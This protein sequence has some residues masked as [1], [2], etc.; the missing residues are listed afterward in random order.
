MFRT[1]RFFVW[2]SGATPTA[3][4]MLTMLSGLHR[5]N[6]WIDGLAGSG[7]NEIC[8]LLSLVVCAGYMR[9]KRTYRWFR[10]TSKKP[11]AEMQVVSRV[12][13]EHPGRDHRRSFRQFRAETARLSSRS[14]DFRSIRRRCRLCRHR[15]RYAERRGFSLRLCVKGAPIPLNRSVI[16]AHLKVSRRNADPIDEK[17]LNYGYA[18]TD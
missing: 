17:A 16:V 12:R 14:N 9:A 15:R 18:G 13:R 3:L 8:P 1:R 4:S 6:D 7:G 5:E 2:R 11:E 10:L